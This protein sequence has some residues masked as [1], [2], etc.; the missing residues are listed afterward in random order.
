LT[1][2]KNIGRLLLVFCLLLGV[3]LPAFSQEAE[4]LIYQ[5]CQEIVLVHPD[6]KPQIKSIA[7]GLRQ[8]A[9]KQTANSQ[10]LQT[11]ID[12]QATK[13]TELQTTISAFPTLLENLTNSH[14]KV[15]DDLKAYANSL[16]TGLAVSTSVG[17]ISL[18]GNLFQALAYYYKK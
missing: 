11:T 12:G 4:D 7:N 10:A 8:I 6:M 18:L 13:I 2:S 3:S 9:E 16:E 1:G 17:V 5:A 14:I 15:E